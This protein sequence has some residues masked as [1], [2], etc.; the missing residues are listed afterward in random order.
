MAALS[1]FGVLMCLLCALVSAN[2]ADLAKKM[3]SDFK[4]EGNATA[5]SMGLW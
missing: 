2:N 1:F 5:Y 4:V 3:A